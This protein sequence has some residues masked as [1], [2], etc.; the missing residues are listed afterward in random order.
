M[1]ITNQE[2]QNKQR[3]NS[4]PFAD[5]MQLR[6]QQGVAL[7]PDY[8]V[9]AFITAPTGTGTPYLAS[10]TDGSVQIRDL[11]TRKVI[12][13]GVFDGDVC[14]LSDTSGF[15]RSAGVLVAGAGRTR[16]A[17]PSNFTCVP[18]DALFASAA[19][20]HLRVPGVQG[21]IVDNT[22]ISG[23]VLFEGGAGV[24]VETDEATN[25][26]VVDIVGRRTAAALRDTIVEC[27]ELP[28]A[29]RAIRVTVEPGSY[30]TAAVEDNKL[31]LYP[32]FTQ[33]MICPPDTQTLLEQAP[34]IFMEDCAEVIPTESFTE[35][36]VFP[37]DGVIRVEARAAPDGS[38]PLRVVRM[39]GSVTPRNFERTIRSATNV[40]QVETVVR[41]GFGGLAAENTLALTVRGVS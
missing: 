28:P 4:Y 29:I 37:R 3:G 21:F 16:T 20:V 35:F 7:P 34:P 2:Q 13:A 1:Q 17:T 12:A 18:T 10:V 25:R 41:Q 6:T 14:E 36:F 24:Q 39:D 19:F 38:Y 9:D 11:V 15:N 27:L 31:L 30:I 5:N 23:H 40:K 26:V 33:D 22:M 32:L 8:L